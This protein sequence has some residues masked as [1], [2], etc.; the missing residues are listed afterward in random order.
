M[1]HTNQSAPPAEAPKGDIIKFVPF[2]K[3]DALVLTVVAYN[4]IASHPFKRTD[5]VTKLERIENKPAIEFFFGAR[6]GD[7]AYFVKPWPQQYSLHE[8]ANYSKWYEAAVGQA[9]AAGTK[10]DDMLGRFVMGTVNLEDKKRKDGSAY[11]ITKLGSV[12]PV[13]S[14]LAGTGTAREALLTALQDALAGDK[15]NPY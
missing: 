14:L 12:T 13:P 3:K 10:P 1:S 5:E 2:P 15:E 7:K 8:K 11:T 9:P 4:Y 6:I